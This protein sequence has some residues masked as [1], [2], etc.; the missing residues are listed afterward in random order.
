MTSRPA[1]L[2]ALSLAWAGHGV[3]AA[4]APVDSAKPGQRPPAGSDEDELWYAM[5]RAERE[6]QQH[7]LLV[8]DEALNAYVRGVACKVA[9]DYCSD[10]RVYIV[11]QPWFNASMAPNGMMVVWTGALLRFQDEAELALVLGHEF[12]HFRQRHSLQMWRKAKRTSAVL[13]SFGLLAYGGGA[14]AAGYLANFIGVAQMYQFSREAERESDRLGFA[15]ATGQGY[16]ADAG[17]RLW[18]RMKDEEDARRYGK[19]IPVFASHP[20]TAERL[21]DVQAAAQA[22]GSGGDAGREG[23][24]QAVRPFLADWL[25]DELS[26]RMYDTSIRVITDLRAL[27]EPDLQATYTFF[28][29][30]AYRRRGKDGDAAQAAALYAQAAS[31][32]NPP[33]AAFR[34]QGMA[35]RAAGRRDEAAAALTRYL[36]LAPEAEDAAFIRHYLTELESRP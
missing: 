27:S 7:P 17:T 34:E 2:L 13:S 30:E 11:E 3:A 9:A 21:A 10:L 24:R 19:P 35:L 29:G 5:E 12:A 25:E 23:Y 16:D 36:A 14:G 28:L 32:E 1:L 20:K 18:Q 31:G 4:Q 22:S 8:R 15:A 6:L 33:P 26:R